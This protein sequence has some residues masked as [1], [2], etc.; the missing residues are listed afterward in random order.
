[1]GDEKR[2]RRCFA[3]RCDHVGTVRVDEG[4]KGAAEG[5][6][7]SFGVAKRDM[8]GIIGRWSVEH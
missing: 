6:G 8:A 2:L 7:G 3:K 1:L 4:G 5:E